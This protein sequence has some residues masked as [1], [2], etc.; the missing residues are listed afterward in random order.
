MTDSAG[1]IEVPL[2]YVRHPSHFRVA[3]V[4][5]STED[6]L[7]DNAIVPMHGITFEEKA[8]NKGLL[9][10]EDIPE[11]GLLRTAGR[12][13]RISG[14][15][16]SMRFR[17]EAPSPALREAPHI[18]ILID[19]YDSGTDDTGL[20]IRYVSRERQSTETDAVRLTNTSTWKQHQFRLANAC[21]GEHE[22]DF[23]VS[24]VN[25]VPPGCDNQYY[26]RTTIVLTA[27]NSKKIRGLKLPP[28]NSSRPYYEAPRLARALRYVVFDRQKPEDLCFNRLYY[29]TQGDGDFTRTAPVDGTAELQRDEKGHWAVIFPPLDF[30][31]APNDL[32]YSVS[33]Y[34]SYYQ[35]PKGASIAEPQ[36]SLY[37][38][39]YVNCSYHGSLQAG[40]RN[41]NIILRDEIGIAQFDRPQWLKP[42]TRAQNHFWFQG[43][44]LHISTAEREPRDV[45]MIG[46][47]ARI[48]EQFPMLPHQLMVDGTLYDVAVCLKDQKMV[49]TPVPGPLAPLNLGCETEWLRLSRD[50]YGRFLLIIGAGKQ[51]ML[52]HGKYRLDAYC[53]AREDEEG[54]LWRAYACALDYNQKEVVVDGREDAALQFGEPFRAFIDVSSRKP[55]FGGG[56]KELLM[57]WLPKQRDLSFNIRGAMDERVQIFCVRG[58]S[59]M[60][61]TNACGLGITD[62]TYRILDARERIL[63]EAV[64]EW[65]SSQWTCPPGAAPRFTECTCDLGP[66]KVQCERHSVY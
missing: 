4:R 31:A 15:D 55:F 9:M 62:V 20:C 1:T 32:P 56:W 59:A 43:D 40:V 10:L 6:I 33:C 34:A 64:Y 66:F 53:T 3:Q 61:E 63:T 41:Y 58:R 35:T 24:A 42:G 2:S 28:L 17:V 12:A 16:I 44:Y 52:P 57:P 50:D 11:I 60:R 27:I 22:V 47:H 25:T 48:W 45:W 7:A 8:P 51:I 36:E 13:C 65:A 21:L 14:L 5:L 30:I 49:L 26:P 38:S 29:D 54:G 18:Y 46:P 23:A 19:Y 37:S 39:C